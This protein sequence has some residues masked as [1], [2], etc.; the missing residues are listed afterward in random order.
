MTATGLGFDVHATDGAA[1][2]GTLTTA[3]GTWKRRPSCR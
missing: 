2:R 1:R 3:H